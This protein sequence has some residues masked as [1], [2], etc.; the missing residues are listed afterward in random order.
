MRWPFVSV[1]ISQQASPSMADNLRPLLTA[2]AK[3]PADDTHL[4]HVIRMALRDQVLL[5]EN[6]KDLPKPWSEAEAPLR[7]Y[8]MPSSR[9]PMSTS[10]GSTAAIGFRPAM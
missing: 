5:A 7:G 9:L 6:W 1:L 3:V 4:L 10:I 2:R 8:F